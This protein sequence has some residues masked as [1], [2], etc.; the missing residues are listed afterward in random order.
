MHM[1]HNL[2][3][4]LPAGARLIVKFELYPMI[5]KVGLHSFIIN[6]QKHDRI[7]IKILNVGAQEKQ[8]WSKRGP[9]RS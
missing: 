8:P 4:S 3:K 1:V 9:R 5:V 7:A 2:C 6:L